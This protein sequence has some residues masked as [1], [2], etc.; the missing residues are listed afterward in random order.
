M[1]T[2]TNC[3]E[4]ATGPCLDFE[5]LSSSSSSLS[6]LRCCHRPYRHVVIV[7]A[8]DVIV[9]FFVVILKRHFEATQL[10]GE[11][12]EEERSGSYGIY[13]MSTV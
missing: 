11:E 3:S 9:V 13:T 1:K 5:I 7:D 4:G 12:G 2:R 8:I 10:V 6:S